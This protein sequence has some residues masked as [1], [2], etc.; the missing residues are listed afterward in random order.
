MNDTQDDGNDP[1]VDLAASSGLTLTCGPCCEHKQPWMDAVML[2][3]PEIA[4]ALDHF[5]PVSADLEAEV[6]RLR[7]DAA[8]YREAAEGMTAARVRELEERLM[9]ETN[10]HAYE[11]DQ[12]REA[13]AVEEARRKAAERRI[14]DA[15]D[16]LDEAL[17]Y[18]RREMVWCPSDE[19]R[20]LGHE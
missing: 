20:A 13:L 1:L 15:M 16:A 4:A 11:L 2:H 12:A 18:A 19:Q 8:Y 9:M 6:R 7:I 10:G 14:E 5:A 3:K 17:D